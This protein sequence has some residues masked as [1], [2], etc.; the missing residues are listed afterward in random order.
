MCWTKFFTLD[1]AHARNASEPPVSRALASDRRSGRA[2]R[3]SSLVQPKR[4]EFEVPGRP[5]MLALIR[6]RVVEFARLMPFSDEEIEDIRLAV[7]E[8]GANAIRHGAAARPCKVR[9]RMERRPRSLKISITDRGCGFDPASVKPPALGSL[10][11][12]GRGIAI[13]RS[14]MDDVAFRSMHPGTRVELVK[15]VKR[16][17]S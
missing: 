8:A 1:A 2:P 6:S 14:V 9:V 17:R 12:G 11:E 3:R 5:T 16:T 4:V 13:M 15:R 7:G 10:E